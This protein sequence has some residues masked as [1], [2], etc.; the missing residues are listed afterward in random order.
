MKMI[1][2]RAL[3]ECLKKTRFRWSSATPAV[4]S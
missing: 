1:G 3:I 4:L 2:A